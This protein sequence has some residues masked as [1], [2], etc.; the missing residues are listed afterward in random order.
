MELA[1]EESSSSDAVPHAG[2]GSG[3]R[4]AARAFLILT[5]ALLILYITSPL[6]A[7]SWNL[8]IP[9]EDVDRDGITLSETIPLRLLTVFV[10]LWIVTL[11]TCVGSFLNVVIYRSPR[12]RTLLGTSKCPRCG[13]PIRARH[14][15]PVLGWIMLEGRCHDCRLPI[16]AR[17]PLVEAVVGFVFLTIAAVEIVGGGWNLPLALRSSH[18][19]IVEVFIVPRVELIRIAS[20][21]VGLLTILLSWG[22]IQWDRMRIPPVYRLTSFLVLLLLSPLFPDLYPVLY[23]GMSGLGHP[24]PSAMDGLAT[25]VLGG[26]VGSCAGWFLAACGTHWTLPRHDLGP[27]REFL[28][29]SESGLALVGMAL[30]WQVVSSISLLVAVGL[31]IVA[32]TPWARRWE[33]SWLLV[34][35]IVTWIHLLAW[36]PIV[37]GLWFVGPQAGWMGHVGMLLLACTLL[38]LNR[39]SPLLE[40]RS[41]AHSGPATCNVSPHGPGL[42]ASAPTPSPVPSLGDKGE[43]EG[44]TVDAPQPNVEAEPLENQDDREPDETSYTEV[45]NPVTPPS[46][47][48]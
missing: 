6:I 23:T 19:G 22:L 13:H 3:L 28:R 42:H 37:S 18:T 36:A 1:R 8:I 16:S 12:G 47:H 30:G 14:N 31:L 20:L 9:Q 40:V 11:G 2:R 34:L 24:T 35:F 39:P 27:R 5:A 26:I 45:E 44:G 10:V 33:S 7:H 38:R 4:I 41:S 48:P 46:P 32:R 43:Q 17:Y 29:E 25:A 21:H 15:I